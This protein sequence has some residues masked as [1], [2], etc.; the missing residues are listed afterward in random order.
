MNKRSRTAPSLVA[1]SAFAI[2]VLIA[3]SSQCHT[4]SERLRML[5]SEDPRSCGPVAQYYARYPTSP[6]ATELDRAVPQ[7]VRLLTD[8]S[9]GVRRDAAAALGSL[10]AKRRVSPSSYR[11][12]LGAV[13]ASASDAVTD[14]RRSAVDAVADACGNY[15]C[16][17]AVMSV[18]R[19]S[20][21]DPDR[22]ARIYAIRALSAVQGASRSEAIALLKRSASRADSL[23]ARAAKRALWGNQWHE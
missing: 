20:V 16:D 2:C 10:M 14:V 17:A 11:A 15:V 4:P 19:E 23:E 8:P 3:L 1:A 21:E 6:A 12:V 5:G 18:L 7:L 9:A 13:I 22:V